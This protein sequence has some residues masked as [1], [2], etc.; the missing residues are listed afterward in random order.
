[1]DLIEPPIARRGKKF[2]I[3]KIFV[4]RNKDMDVLQDRQYSLIKIEKEQTCMTA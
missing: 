4:G 3:K 2:K 1:M